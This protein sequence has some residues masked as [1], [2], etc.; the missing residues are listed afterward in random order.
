MPG[1]APG[2]LRGDATLPQDTAITLAIVSPVSLHA[3]RFAQGPT[4]PAGD[5][6]NPVE[7]RHELRRIVAVSACQDDIQW[8]AVAIDGEVVLA[9][10][11]AP[12]SR[13]GP[14]F[15]PPCT[16]RTDELSAITRE[17]SSR[18]ALRSFVSKMQCS[19]SHTPASC[20]S[21]ARRQHVMPE[22]HPISLGSNSQGKPVCKTKIMPVNMHRSSR[23]LR[24]AGD[25]CGGGGGSNGR[26]IS[27][28][29]SSTNSR[30][31]MSL[32]RTNGKDRW[33]AFIRFC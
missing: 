25:L 12:I 22:P 9:T 7:Q 23:R 19:F 8:C 1:A 2:D 29:S 32:H 14:S 18:S 6:G 3:P 26:T 11:L 4:T 31:M 15:F 5:C 17:K 33:T 16:A 13:V 20:Q 30:A 28:S 24:P 21:R 27:H 10:R